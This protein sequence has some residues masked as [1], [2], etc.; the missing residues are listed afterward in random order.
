MGTWQVEYLTGYPLPVLQV[1]MKKTKDDKH[2]VFHFFWGRQGKS[3]IKKMYG[4]QNGKQI[5]ILPKNQ[6]RKI[7][8][9]SK[10]TIELANRLYVTIFVTSS[11]TKLAVYEWFKKG[12]QI[13]LFTCEEGKICNFISPLEKRCRRVFIFH[14]CYYISSRSIFLANLGE[15]KE[16]FVE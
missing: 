3:Y 4:W 12:I 1:N 2:F 7:Y 16:P 11:N 14:K 15:K 8:L 10:M 13:G 5:V 9:D 6:N